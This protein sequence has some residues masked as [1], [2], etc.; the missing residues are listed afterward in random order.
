MKLTR[1][2]ITGAD[3][4]AE[5]EALLELS[6]NFGFVEWGILRGGEDRLGSPRY[7]TSGWVRRW[8]DLARRFEKPPAWSLHLCG[9][10]SRH[11]MAGSPAVFAAIRGLSAQR[12]QLN[13]FSPFALPMLML[14]QLLPEHEFI[15]QCQNERA[16]AKASHLAK[17][18]P[19][20]TALW[21]I[22]GGRGFLD[23][24]LIAQLCLPEGIKTGRAGG[25]AEDNI[26][27]VLKRLEMLDE[28]LWIDLESGSRTENRFDLD[29]V[30]RILELAAPFV[31]RA[32]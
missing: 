21:D 25:I 7:P 24:E 18:H 3:D 28:E 15:L 20:V 4:G 6:A 9:E 14:A 22:S 29:K 30:V 16:V 1:V 23:I 12:V 17:L 19:N 27:R 10:V 2:T 5:P 26:E 31:A 32:A 13:G 11:A 8:D